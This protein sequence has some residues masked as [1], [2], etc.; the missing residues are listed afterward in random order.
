M[1]PEDRARTLYYRAKAYY[2]TQQPALAMA[3]EDQPIGDVAHPQ[4]AQFT[5]P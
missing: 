4:S 3:D 2:A 1:S 5:R